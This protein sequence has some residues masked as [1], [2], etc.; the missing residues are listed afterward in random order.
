MIQS[1][2]VIQMIFNQLWN[3]LHSKLI[4]KKKISIFIM[5]LTN[6]FHTIYYWYSSQLLNEFL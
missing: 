5:I 1:F 2:N 6:P 4:F 3:K